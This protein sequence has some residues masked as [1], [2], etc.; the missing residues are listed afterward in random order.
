MRVITEMP[1][2]CGVYVPA[3]E[4]VKAIQIDEDFKIEFKRNN[5][6]VKLTGKAGDYL[7]EKDK[8]LFVIFSDEYFENNYRFVAKA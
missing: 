6:I 2:D 4:P 3:V 8:D 5:V 7:A 1:K